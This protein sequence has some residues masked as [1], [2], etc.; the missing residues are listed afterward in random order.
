MEGETARQASRNK[1]SAPS[2]AQTLSISETDVHFRSNN[3]EGINSLKYV[4]VGKQTE[5][6]YTSK[7]TK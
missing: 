3:F 4:N 7:M 1:Q 6:L 5:N 2:K